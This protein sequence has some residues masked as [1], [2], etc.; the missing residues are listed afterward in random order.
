MGKG[1]KITT[2]VSTK[3]QVVLPAALRK[4][5]GWD[6]GT[7]LVVEETSQGVLLK[8]NSPFGPPTRP[9]DVF[10][11]LKYKGPPI[12]IEDMDKAIEREV[13]RRHALGEY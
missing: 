1:P 9:E 4:R 2:T 5:F 3:G 13:R 11:M 12:S 10:G 6:V 8:G 7:K